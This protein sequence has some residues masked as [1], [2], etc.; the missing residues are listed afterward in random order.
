M[1]AG[2]GYSALCIQNA[3][4]DAQA[5]FILFQLCTDD[6]ALLKQDRR[7][8]FHPRIYDRP[9][10]A[11]GL[12]LP[13]PVIELFEQGFTSDLEITEVVTVPHHAHG[14]GIMERDGDFNPDGE[15]RIVFKLHV[16]GPCCVGDGAAN[17]QKS[18]KLNQS[19]GAS[20]Q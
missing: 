12:H 5:V 4:A 18:K 20:R 1:A 14:I 11:R 9:D 7:N 2:G 13:V 19:S 15:S 10:I 8:I 3:V 6:D 17:C 16:S